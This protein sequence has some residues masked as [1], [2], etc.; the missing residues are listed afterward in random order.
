M[1]ISLRVGARST[2]LSLRQAGHAIAALRARGIAADLR[3]LS[4]SGDRD[5]VSP[6]QDL[7]G[8]APFADDLQDALR[9][10]EIDVA[11]HSLKD[12]ALSPPPDLTIA[13]LLPRGSVTESLVSQRGLTLAELPPGAVIGTSSPRRRAQILMLRPDL[14]CRAIRGPVGARVGQVIAGTFD[15][16]ILA[17]AGLERLDL[18]SAIVETFDPRRFV[19]AAGQGAL[20]LQ[21]RAS[22]RRACDALQALDHFPTR[23]AATAE[24]AAERWLEEA[25]VVAAAAATVHHVSVAVHTRALSADGSQV[26]DGFA[27]GLEPLSVARAAVARTLEPLGAAAR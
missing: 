20:A 12:L 24:R 4:S 14:V 26:T 8:D 15:A 6:I 13:A 16:A 21:T 25:G 19:P 11:V 9:A 2:P 23:L 18:A 17:T 27:F 3:T 5:R 7:P 1:S 22:D 10:G